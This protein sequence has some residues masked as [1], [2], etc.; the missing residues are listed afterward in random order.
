MAL[1]GLQ[2]AESRSTDLTRVWLF[3]CVDQD[4]GT[5][6]CHLWKKGDRPHGQKTSVTH[7]TS[8]NNPLNFERL[9]QMDRA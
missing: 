3:S 2:V 4:V 7:D 1:E 9:R 8:D 5:Q 6:M